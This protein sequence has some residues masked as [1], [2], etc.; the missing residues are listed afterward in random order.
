MKCARKWRLVVYHLEKKGKILSSP[1]SR[2]MRLV[3]FSSRR[4]SQICDLSTTQ[5]GET[6]ICLKEDEENPCADGDPALKN[7][8]VGSVEN[9]CTSNFFVGDL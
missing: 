4:F 6:L 1:F 5:D 8:V 3:G 7:V 9:E 2:I